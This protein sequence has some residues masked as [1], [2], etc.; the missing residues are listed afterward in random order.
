MSRNMTIIAIC[1]SDPMSDSYRHHRGGTGEPGH[2]ATEREKEQYQKKP[3]RGE[4]EQQED[5]GKRSRHR[6]DEEHQGGKRRKAAA[7]QHKNLD[8]RG[9]KKGHKL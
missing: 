3:D 2:P 7:E 1:W 5:Q 6:T 9:K 8:I 4:E